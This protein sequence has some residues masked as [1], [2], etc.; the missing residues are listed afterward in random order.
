[1]IF[2]I[3]FL[4]LHLSLYKNYF[5]LKENFVTK[6]FSPLSLFIC[7]YIPIL[8]LFAFGHDWGR[9]MNITYSLSILLYLY[10]LK[11][12]IISTNFDNYS[13][14]KIFFKKKIFAYFSILPICFFLESKNFNQ[15]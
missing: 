6:Y 15:W 7:L 4:P 9:W 3:G 11:E 14:I 8:L 5:I 2:L 10:F 12:K 13:I 1:M